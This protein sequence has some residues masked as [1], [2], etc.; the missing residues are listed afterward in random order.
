[1]IIRY[2]ARGFLDYRTYI[3]LYWFVDYLIYSGFTSTLLTAFEVG[4][5]A[6]D[7]LGQFFA[8]L[9]QPSVWRFGDGFT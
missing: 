8:I 1:M 2:L 7:H 5:I 4:A 9:F 6:I 3:L